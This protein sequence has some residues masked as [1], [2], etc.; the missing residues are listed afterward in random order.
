MPTLVEYREQAAHIIGNLDE[1]TPRS[2]R[3]LVSL[4]DS[5]VWHP[6]TPNEGR[7]FRSLQRT[8]CIE[9]TE[10]CLYCETTYHA[11][12]CPNCGAPPLGAM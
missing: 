4:S 7:V 8:L 5:G 12:S 1:I 9:P 2:A 11:R 10:H 3:F 6:T